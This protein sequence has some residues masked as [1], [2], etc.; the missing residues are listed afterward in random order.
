MTIAI[1]G[2]GGFIGRALVAAAVARGERVQAVT[3]TAPGGIDPI[4]GLLP[5]DFAFERGTSSVYFLAQSPHF[6]QVPERAAHLLTV[7]Q[8][9]AV[10][11][12][13]AARA[14][15][16]SR[17]IYLST[18]NVYA[19]SFLPLAE[20]APLNRRDW[21]ALSKVHGEEALSLLAP[22][23]EIVRV[24]LFGAYGPG[25]SGR[26]VSNLIESVR[27]GR[28]ITLQPREA[29]EAEPEG[30]RVSVCYIDDVVAMLLRLTSA[31]M[32]SIVNLAGP[33]PCSIRR[34]AVL[35]GSLLGREPR[36]QTAA[37]PR[38]FDLVAE[39]GLLQRLLAPTFTPLD[40]GLQ[41]T[42]TETPF[43]A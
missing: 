16:A 14:C 23:I 13:N 36:F 38:P 20:D 22:S 10:Q 4:S 25:Q 17:F 3:S 37:N 27:E 12:A 30:L 40:V 5:N 8:I 28:T 7:N 2:A 33:E 6:R 29:D 15:G 24:R 34:I 21:Y 9:A 42:V 11:C 18:G 39:V 43:D 35:L 19:P 1:I 26:L 41:R 31:T 32:P